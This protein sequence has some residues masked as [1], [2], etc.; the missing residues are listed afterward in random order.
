MIMKKTTNR[1]KKSARATKQKT[2]YVPVSSNVYFDGHS[3]RVRVSFNGTR[4]SQN[5]SSKRKAITFR[6]TVQSA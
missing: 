2:V 4:I 5:F 6:N 1:M 3:Y